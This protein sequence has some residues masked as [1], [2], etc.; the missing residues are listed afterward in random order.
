MNTE[1]TSGNIFGYLFFK[2]FFYIT[3]KLE[4]KHR[5]LKKENSFWHKIK[6]IFIIFKVLLLKSKFFRRWDPNVKHHICS[7]TFYTSIRFTF[8]K[9]ITNVRYLIYFH[10]VYTCVFFYSEAVTQRC[11]TKKVHLKISQNS[12]ENTGLFF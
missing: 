9:I 1:Q 11:S 6:N 3:K 7:T 8:T 5:Y 12:R 2:P 10:T 4:Q